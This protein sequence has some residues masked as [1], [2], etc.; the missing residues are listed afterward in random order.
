MAL[1]KDPFLYKLIIKAIDS[2]SDRHHVTGRSYFAPLLGYRG[3]NASI[4][5]ST[6]LNY[7]TYNPATPKPLSIDQFKV[8]LD[9][10]GEDRNIIIDG[11]LREYDLI[12]VHKKDAQENTS[13]LN[14]LADSANM[15]NADV[16]RAVK[17]SMSDGKITQ[18]ERERIIKELEEAQKANAQMLHFVKN[19]PVEE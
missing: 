17:E 3:E 14:Q 13:D 1:P 7:T 2:F 12:A 19:I 6:A 4:M 8:L 15:E 5:L 10:L 18:E 11:L 9:E 16:F